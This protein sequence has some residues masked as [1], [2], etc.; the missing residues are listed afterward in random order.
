[1][2][3]QNGFQNKDLNSE[4]VKVYPIEHL[5]IIYG[6]EILKIIDSLE[7]LKVSSINYFTSEMKDIEKEYN[8]F[9]SEINNNIN[10]NASKMVK[11]FK[12]EEALNGKGDKETMDMVLKIN[13]DKISTIK[14]ILSAHSKIIET[15]KENIICL[16]KFLNI[17]QNFDTNSLHIFYEK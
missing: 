4:K 9:H 17:C 6:D 16:K 3:E 7:D 2:E 12:L 1:M 5:K 10:I 8:I 13:S 15:I 11:Y 14:S